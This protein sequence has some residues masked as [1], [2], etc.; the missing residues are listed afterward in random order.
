MLVRLRVGYLEKAPTVNDLRV[1][2]YA[3][4]PERGLLNLVAIGVWRSR[5]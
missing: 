2:R 3:R 4:A 1:I 5:Y